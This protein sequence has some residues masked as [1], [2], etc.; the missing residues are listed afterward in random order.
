MP[1][2]V[3]HEMRRADL[4]RAAF[5]IIAKRGFAA[6]TV[7]EIAREA[8]FT[9]GSIPHY[10]KSKDQLLLAASEYS[11]ATVHARLVI[12]EDRFDGIEAVRQWFWAL[13]PLDEEKAGHWNIWGNFWGQSAQ[14][15]AVQ[16][17]MDLRYA[18]ATGA[19]RRLMKRAQAAGE[20]GP[21]IDIQLAA[22]TASAM[23]SGFGMQV[24]VSGLRNIPARVQ[25]ACVENWIAHALAVG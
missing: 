16:K 13:L 19:F 10:V 4:A 17:M 20:I 22:R 2:K 24:H 11:A 1:K 18:E 14:S 15:G 12:V 3:D 21:R 6:A 9:H 7:R 5:R 23:V 8:G 25:K